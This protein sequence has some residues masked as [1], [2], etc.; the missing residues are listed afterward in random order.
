MVRQSAATSPKSARA[1]FS[2]LPPG[3]SPRL[4]PCVRTAAMYP[5]VGRQI[6]T[7]SMP[8]VLRY[9]ANAD[10]ARRLAAA[11]SAMG[12]DV[13]VTTALPDSLSGQL[14]EEIKQ[15]RRAEDDL[16]DVQ[17]RFDLAVRGAG[18]GI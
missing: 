8:R 1:I 6:W 10:E 13:E 2:P 16:R 15:H 9:D 17:E 7:R 11:L 18:D 3:A 5:D 12:L 4:F 14:H